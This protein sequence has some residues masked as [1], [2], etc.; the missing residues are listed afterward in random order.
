MIIVRSLKVKSND[1]RSEHAA[2]IGGNHIF[3]VDVSILSTVFL[4]NL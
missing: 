2:L 1:K 4:K 3:Y